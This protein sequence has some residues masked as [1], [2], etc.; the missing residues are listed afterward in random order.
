MYT[1]TLIADDKDDILYKAFQAEQV[2]TKRFN[3]K[4]EKG[5]QKAKILIT[6]ADATALKAITTSVTK[7][8]EIAERIQNDT[9]F[10]RRE[11][12]LT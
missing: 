12:G 6:A 11:K 2:E 8:C 7:L 9:T 1:L 10:S 3:M 5:K 4:V